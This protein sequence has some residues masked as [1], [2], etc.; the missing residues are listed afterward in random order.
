MLKPFQPY[1]P[2]S[3]P[4]G[5]DAQS[6]DW[7]VKVGDIAHAL[8]ALSVRDGRG[9]PLPPGEAFQR[10]NDLTI[11]L[12]HADRTVYLIGNGASASMASHMAAD[13]AKNAHVNTQ[14]FTDL[15]LM[16]AMAN[17]FS[18]E[19][20]FAESLAQRMRPGD[21]LVAISS[22]GNSPNIVKACHVARNLKGSVITVSA[23]SA[24]NKIRLLGELNYWIPADTYGLAETCHAALLHFW[25]DG[26]AAVSERPR[27]GQRTLAL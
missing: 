7:S 8:R 1:G 24:E 21:M 19:D 3:A 14:V 11:A 10:W 15:A 2:H 4:E 23:M 18:Y 17:D 20:V 27:P 6:F 5:G 16:T 22:S 12:R 26:L 13:L 9:R 25:M